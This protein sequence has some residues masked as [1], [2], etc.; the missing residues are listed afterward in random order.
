MLRFE[1]ECSSSIARVELAI[2]QDDCSIANGCHHLMVE[3]VSL[4]WTPFAFALNALGCHLK[5]RFTND[6]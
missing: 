4:Q 2:M 6:G 3:D 5:R 1:L